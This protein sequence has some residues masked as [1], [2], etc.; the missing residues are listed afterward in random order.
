MAS[1]L[2]TTCL[3]AA[4]GSSSNIKRNLNQDDVF[5]HGKEGEVKIV[6]ESQYETNISGIATA[7]PEQHY[8][9]LVNVKEAPTIQNNAKHC[10]TQSVFSVLPVEQYIGWDVPMSGVVRAPANSGVSISVGSGYWVGNSLR[11]SSTKNL[12][13]V[14][15]FL[16]KG[17]G[18]AYDRSWTTTYSAGYSYTIPKGKYGAIVS[19]P[20]ITK[21]SGYVD[22]GC[23]GSSTRTEF[24]VE[25]YKSKEFAHMKWVDGIISLCLGDTYP[26]PKCTGNGT[27]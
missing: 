11:I 19:N 27:L 16:V 17:L 24:S 18:V 23:I 22:K 9:N 13:D 8:G 4:R 14:K 21:H 7:S 10:K 12:D 25:S 3:A 1:S 20:L 2:A 26:L 6:P 15:L 5:L